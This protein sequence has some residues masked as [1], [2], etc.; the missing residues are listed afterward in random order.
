VAVADGT[1]VGT[2]TLAWGAEGD[3]EAAFLVEDAWFRRGIGRALFAAIAREARADRVPAVV[4]RVQ[5][6][7]H[8]VRGFLASLA[9]GATTTHEGG[10]DLAVR[11]PVTRR[12]QVAQTAPLAHREAS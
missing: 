8:R 4:A 11:L 3:P 9:P 7:N 12:R 5:A 10:G 6:D 1:V 2:A